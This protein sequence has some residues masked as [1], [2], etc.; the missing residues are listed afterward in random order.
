MKIFFKSFGVVFISA[1]MLLCTA[2]GAAKDISSLSADQSGTVLQ[3]A[4]SSEAKPLTQISANDNTMELSVGG[5]NFCVTLENNETVS[6]L[7]ELIPLTIDMSELNGNEKYHYLDTKLPSTP[8]KVGNI[9]SGDI[10]LFGDNCLVVFYKSF[11]TSYAYTKIG[12]IEEASELETLLGNSNVTVSFSA[13]KESRSNDTSSILVAYFSRTGNTEKIARYLTELSGADTYVINA[14][15]PYTDEDIEYNN[16]SCRANKEQNDK[17]VRPEI[18]NPKISIESYDTIF[19]GYPIW[20]GQEPRIIDTFLE[21]YDF[22]EKTVIPFCT[23]HSSGISASEANI[24]ALVP[25]G[26]Q[27]TGKRFSAD[28]TKDEVA[29]WLNTLDIMNKN[30]IIYSTQD[31]RDLSDFLLGKPT[32]NDL[33][34]K[35]YDLDNDDTWS[36]FDLVLMRKKILEQ[37][38]MKTEFDFDSR[39]V[40]LNSGYEMPILGLGTWTQD[41]ETVEGSVYTALKDGYRLID[42]AQ[43][44]G[45]ETGV[46][47]GLKRAI[48]EGVVKREDVFITTK[49]MPSNYE[50]AYQSIDDSLKRLNVDYIDLMLIHQSGSKD[51]EVYKALCQG[52]R[53]GK[54]RSIGISNYYTPE[55]YERVTAGENIKPAVVQNENHPFYQNTEFKEYVSKYGTVVESWY[56]FGGRGHT[57]DLFENETIMEI[58]EA[59]GKTSAQIILRW[60]L[61]AGYITIPGSQN[62]DHILENISVFDF[63]LSDEEMH[64]MR[65]LHTGKRYENW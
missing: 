32:E 31:L 30:D 4:S 6:A 51:T 63:D 15:V 59:H 52:V 22:S 49:V 45:N 57:Q 13:D 2:C 33:T 8:Q 44:Y 56:P 42:T 55:E 24:K 17:T 7:K 54:L 39:T 34:G 10:M 64:R 38:N 12:H 26:E 41:D 37:K 61:Q 29:D 27:L 48:S 23:S 11:E 36:T 28:S 65:T 60:H 25:I 40:L 14:A 5:K 62:P 16:N 21:R 50:R 35:N 20:W 19:L 9:S 18:A 1:A 43:Y 46:G 3:T 58:A 53:D 47:N